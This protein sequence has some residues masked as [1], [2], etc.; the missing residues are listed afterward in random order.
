MKKILKILII[1]LII[2]YCMANLTSAN[3]TGLIAFT[4]ES[5]HGN[6]VTNE[7]EEKSS[8]N[9]GLIIGIAFIVIIAFSF[10]VIKKSRKANTRKMP[11]NVYN[12]EI[13]FGGD[14]LYSY[15]IAKLYRITNNQ[16][17]IPILFM[18]WQIEGKVR[19]NFEKNLIRLKYLYD[20]H[21]NN[22][23]EKEIYNYFLE[24]SENTHLTFFN[25]SDYN[26]EHLNEYLKLED[27]YK[28]FLFREVKKNN[29]LTI[30]Y[31]DKHIPNREVTPEL[32]E[33]AN[34]LFGFKHYL[35][36]IEKNRKE[37]DDPRVIEYY[38]LYAYL[39]NESDV[40]ARQIHHTSPHAFSKTIFRSCE[41]FMD[42]CELFNNC[43]LS[44][45]KTNNKS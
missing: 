24:A 6:A 21:F 7:I 16:S 18:K 10:I 22:D 42:I 36:T 12:S 44:M 34:S 33:E 3:D 15:E 38:L 41:D 13:P 45:K 5:F 20:L 37:I 27:K 11:D 29:K 43:S 39:F 25:L 28:R 4:A 35:E 40:V 26:E 30:D 1:T 32:E 9:P 2:I 8:T 14:I 19:V 17:I 31:T 23:Y